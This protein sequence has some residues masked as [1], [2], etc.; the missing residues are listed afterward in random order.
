M[1]HQHS[2][3]SGVPL[4]TDSSARMSGSLVATPEAGARPGQ[5]QLEF[6]TKR[7]YPLYP[8]VIQ[9]LHENGRDIAEAANIPVTGP[10]GRLLKGDVLA[11]LGAIDKTYPQRQSDRI[12]KLGHLDLHNINRTTVRQP[13]SVP[14]KVKEEQQASSV[15]KNPEITISISFGAV[16]EVQR[17]IHDSLGIDIPLATFITRAIETSNTDLPTSKV[18]LTQEELFNQILGLDKVDSKLSNGAFMPDVTAFSPLSRSTRS[19]ARQPDIVDILAGT[20][21][22][23]AVTRLPF[24]QISPT[25]GSIFSLSVPKTEVERAKI[26]L[27]RVKTILQV[28]PG[29]LVL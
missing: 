11:Y 19:R 18:P 23:S 27:K 14:S 20:S 29:R 9:L 13:E 22:K 25:D 24:R 26:F 16:K 7:N 15:R 8:S 17:R 3:A 2:I 1:Q 6:Q 12:I 10:K 4:A 28:E 21:P 5:K